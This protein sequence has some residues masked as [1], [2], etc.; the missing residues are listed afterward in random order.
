MKDKLLFN[1]QLISK[2][3]SELMGLATIGILMCHAHAYDVVPPFPI[4]KIFGLGQ[5][6]VML[7][8]FLSGVGLSF[9]LSKADFSC[10]STLKWYRRRFARLLVP[11]VIIT[12]SAI[13][14]EMIDNQS[15]N[16]GGCPKSV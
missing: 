7:F 13:L 10:Q 12:G 8:F 15:L 3:R 2:F 4:D 11:Y 16:G 9:S 5:M 14:V 1:T 6:G